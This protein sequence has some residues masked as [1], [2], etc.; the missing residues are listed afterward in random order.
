MCCRT[1]RRYVTSHRVYFLPF[2]LPVSLGAS[3][4][5]FLQLHHS[6]PLVWLLWFQLAP[7]VSL[8]HR[9]VRVMEEGAGR[10]AVLLTAASPQHVTLLIVPSEIVFV[11]VC[12]WWGCRGL[13]GDE[14]VQQITC[15]FSTKSSS[16]C[17]CMHYLYLPPWINMQLLLKMFP[18]PPVHLLG[19]P[20]VC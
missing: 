20:L 5:H 1:F 3:S 6:F 12:V 10:G 16:I 18:K 2:V 11:C 8:S 19:A 7:A 17:V 4:D 9:A 13:W 15:L 14:W